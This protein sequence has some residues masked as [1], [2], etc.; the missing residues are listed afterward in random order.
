MATN[1]ED[2]AGLLSIPTWGK[3]TQPELES[4]LAEAIR[5]RVVITKIDQRNIDIICSSMRSQRRTGRL[6]IDYNKGGISNITFESIEHIKPI[7]K[8]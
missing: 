8:P 7:D 3:L 1:P 5:T 2:I 6:I 4:R